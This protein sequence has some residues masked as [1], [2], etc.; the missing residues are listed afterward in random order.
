MGSA[1]DL[2]DKYW[3]E[4]YGWNSGVK[5]QYMALTVKYGLDLSIIYMN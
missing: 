5:T 3:Q 1:R 4:I 2:Y